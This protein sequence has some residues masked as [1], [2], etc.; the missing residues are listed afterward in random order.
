V[1]Q[2]TD[3]IISFC[4]S[5][6]N[7]SY[8]V[9]TINPNEAQLLQDTYAAA[10]NFFDES[11]QTKE[12]YTQLFPETPRS[13]GLFGWNRVNDAKELLRFRRHFSSYH[14]SNTEWFTS[15]SLE[16]PV[17]SLAKLKPLAYK[18][19]DLL[20]SIVLQSKS[21]ELPTILLRPHFTS[22][23]HLPQIQPLPNSFLL[24]L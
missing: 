8:A 2:D 20:E 1:K 14:Q 9:L 5:I 11:E 16:L 4:N 23:L 18:S 15:T 10:I 13:R 7:K 6:A 21:S 24:R 17:N 12:Q 19:F 22:I 3:A